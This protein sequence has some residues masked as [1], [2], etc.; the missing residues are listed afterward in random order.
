MLAGESVKVPGVDNVT[1]NVAV[2]VPQ[3]P[4]AVTDILPAPAP[5]LAVIALELVGADVMVAPAGTVHV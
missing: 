3:V 2:V 4:V 5:K 1:A